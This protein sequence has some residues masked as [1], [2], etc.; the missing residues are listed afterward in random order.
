MPLVVPNL[1]ELELLDKM[2]SDALSVDENYILKLY[3]NNYT[4]D[5]NSGA[6][7]FVEATFTGYAA[8]TL[9][10]TNWNTAVIVSNKAESSYGTAPQSWTCT[11]TGQTIF[12][13]WIIGATSGTALWAELFSV[14]RV[15]ANGDVLNLTPKFT[16]NSEN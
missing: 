12:G 8:K 16:L 5:Q 1:G 9:T 14:S 4:P 3:T 13:Y 7:S 10:R 11:G 6:N 15:L 2:L